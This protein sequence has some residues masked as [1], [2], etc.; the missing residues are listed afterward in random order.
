MKECEFFLE[1][2]IGYYWNDTAKRDV[3]IKYL[4]AYKL[5]SRLLIGSFGKYFKLRPQR[6]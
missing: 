6:C 3:E 1:S 2:V 4:H 5:I